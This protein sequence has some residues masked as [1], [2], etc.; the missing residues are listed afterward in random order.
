MFEER[1]VS[2]TEHPLDDVIWERRDLEIREPS[3]QVIFKQDNVECPKSWSD[4]ACKVAA[5]LY[6]Y[7]GE[8]SIKDLIA[9]IVNTIA[10]WGSIDGY[11]DAGKTENFVGA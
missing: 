7:E 9:R 1:I 3:G 6:F 2:P 4:L 10:I 11:F 5:R 8:D